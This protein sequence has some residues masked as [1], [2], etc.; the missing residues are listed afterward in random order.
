[1]KI[2]VW[3]SELL[4]NLVESQ[5]WYDVLS[6]ITNKAV[7]NDAKIQV[8]VKNTSWSTIYI[9]RGTWFA[10]SSSFPLDSWEAIWF[11]SDLR[12][13]YFFASAPTVVDVVFY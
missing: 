3:A 11:V 5:Q 7:Y 1:M 2:T 9:E 10:D 12:W 4:T 8:A 6:D 13:L